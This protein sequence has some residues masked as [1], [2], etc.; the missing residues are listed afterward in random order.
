MKTIC[1][2]NCDECPGKDTCP[3]CEEIGGGGKCVIYAC[4]S[5][6]AGEADTGCGACR[7]F[8]GPCAMKEQLLREFNALGIEDLPEVTDLC[9][10]PGHYINLEYTLPSGQKVKLWDDKR[11]YLGYQLE[12]A[13]S[14]RCY[15][16]T[17][18]ENNLLVCEYGCNGSDP[19]IVVYRRRD[20]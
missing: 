17:A 14:D 18:D 9:A 20:K 1:G 4:A 8:D 16:L 5:S 13:G 3:G 15:G 12:K 2:L 11:V 7:Y 6:H 10:L 19:E